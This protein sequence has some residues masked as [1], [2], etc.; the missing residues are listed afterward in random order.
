MSRTSPP[1][2]DLEFLPRGDGVSDS[3]VIAVVDDDA[4]VRRSLKRLVQ[5]AGYRVETFGSPA[6][7]LQWLSKGRAACLV[8]DVHM[9][10][11]SGFDLQERL[12]VPVIFMTGH[13]DAPT[14]HRIEKSGAAGHLWKPFDE[15]VVLDAIRRVLDTDPDRPRIA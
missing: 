9:N 11:M 14:R 13:D 15:Q 3:P 4:S 5:S 7:F 1:T 8:V 10:G 12:A 2:P 6:E